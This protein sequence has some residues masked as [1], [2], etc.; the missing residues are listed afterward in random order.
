MNFSKN[1]KLAAMVTAGLIVTSQIIFVSI[2]QAANPKPTVLCVKP[3]GQIL[4]KS[5]CQKGETRFSLFPTEVKQKPIKQTILGKQRT[6][7]SITRST[8]S[9]SSFSTLSILASTPRVFTS[10]VTLGTGTTIGNVRNFS[11]SMPS[12]PA[13]APLRTSWFAI[14]AD[15]PSLLGANGDVRV[16]SENSTYRVEIDNIQGTREFTRFMPSQ[17]TTN[18]DVLS[19]LRIEIISESGMNAPVYFF[20][21]YGENSVTYGL[22]GYDPSKPNNNILESVTDATTL[23]MDISFYVSV[24]CIPLVTLAP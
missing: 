12:C 10:L 1:T 11:S 16:S 18:S 22:G 8:T 7:P 17:V 4:A 5:K 9:S 2:T 19:T 3:N 23:D 6:T 15:D 20:T 24:S 14:L 13:E 21:S